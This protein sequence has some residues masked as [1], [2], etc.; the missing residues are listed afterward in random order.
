LFYNKKYTFNTTT[1]YITTL[2]LYNLHYYMFL[3]IHV[4]ISESHVCASLIYINFY[5]A[6]IAS[7]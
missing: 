7:L 5:I 3:H 4:I 1:V 6:A 2:T